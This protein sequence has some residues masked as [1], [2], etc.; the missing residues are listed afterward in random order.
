[1][2][3]SN[4]RLR[5]PHRKFRYSIREGIYSHRIWPSPGNFSA[6]RRY[7]DVVDQVK[8]YTTGDAEGEKS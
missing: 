5:R 6:A 8:E 7:Q 3:G 1:M 4:T 2:P